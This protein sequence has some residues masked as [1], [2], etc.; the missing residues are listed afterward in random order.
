MEDKT[1]PDANINATS[2]LGD[3]YPKHGRI[4]AKFNNLDTAWCTNITTK[5]ESLTVS[6]NIS[7]NLSYCLL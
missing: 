7:K 2:Y 3:Y 5:K 4:N 6:A 1:I